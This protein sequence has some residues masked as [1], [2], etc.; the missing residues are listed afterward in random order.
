MIFDNFLIKI[1]FDKTSKRI[2]ATTPLLE[3]NFSLP[4]DV[5]EAAILKKDSRLVPEKRNT[6]NGDSPFGGIYILEENGKIKFF[7]T[8]INIY[9]DIILNPDMKSSEFKFGNF[10]V[11]TATAIKLKSDSRDETKYE[12]YELDK[13]AVYVAIFPIN[14]G[15]SASEFAYSIK[16]SPVVE[17]LNLT[18]KGLSFLD[19]F[20]EYF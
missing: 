13:N 4:Y 18:Y 12:N 8:E 7:S 14:E 17:G 2:F 15:Q 6:Y 20:N 1:V 16:D 11:I 5:M 19:V 9:E 3:P 10:V